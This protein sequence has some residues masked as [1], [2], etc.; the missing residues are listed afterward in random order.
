MR[1]P[2]QTTAGSLTGFPVLGAPLAGYQGGAL[3]RGAL[4][5]AFEELCVT[6][7]AEKFC[8]ADLSRSH[9][10]EAPKVLASNWSFDAIE[11]IGTASIETLFQS[12]F[13]TALA[14]Q[15]RAF[16]TGNPGRSPR[17][18]DETSALRLLEFGHA[19]IFAL[20][21]RAGVRR[22]I[23]LFSASTTDRIRPSKLSP[24]HLM[25]NYLMSL[26]RDGAVS[27]AESPLSERERECL[28]WVSEGKTTDE[29]AL[30][31]NV[32]ANTVNKYIVSS[33][34]KLSASNRSMA[35]ATAIRNGII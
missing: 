13:A 24:A 22:G 3:S 32:S 25:S 19:E 34:Q 6:T 9:A 26:Y 23:C 27:I 14:Q 7:G 2:K 35:I 4:S 1:H 21:L 10:E 12:P 29:V 8:L 17:V 5:Q 20:K 11:I 16:Q 18:V 33:I 15:P 31:I 28:F 30:I